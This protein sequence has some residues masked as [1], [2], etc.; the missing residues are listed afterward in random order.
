MRENHL[1]NTTVAL[2]PILRWAGGK[3]W[4]VKYL[5]G[6]LDIS[7]FSSYVEPFVGGAAVLLSFK[8][9]NAWISDSNK[10][11]IETYKTLRKDSDSV[12][13]I[14]QEWAISQNDYYQIRSLRP[15]DE[16]TAAA[17]FLYLNHT[18]YNGLYRENREGQYN[19]PWGR[20][21]NI[22]YDFDNIR[23]VAR[24]LKSVHIR[25]L[26][27]TRSIDF[28]KK[29]SLVFLDPPYTI[30]HNKN[31]FVAYNQKIFRLSDQYRLSSLIDKIREKEA[32][33]I[34]TNAAHDE[35]INIFKRDNDRMFLLSRASLIGGRNARRGQYEECI[36]T[37]LDITL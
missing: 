8:P 24:Y 13:R 26:D 29:G 27:F 11:L 35:V 25:H 20:R 33:Y 36:F 9:K 10:F 18:S 15:R 4:L 34:L 19:V 14:L 3:S 28:V 1:V 23:E 6:K 22:D 21:Q 32:F 30:T 16:Y 17:R 12:I 2:H 7:L 31:G 37:N 5:T